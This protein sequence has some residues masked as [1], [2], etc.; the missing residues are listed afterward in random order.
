MMARAIDDNLAV[1][2]GA[3]DEWTDEAATFGD[4]LAHARDSVGMSQAQ[5]AQRM[6][7]RLQTVRNWEEN[8]SEPRSNRL[9]TLA[10]MLNVSMVWLMCGQGAAPRAQ[11]GGAADLVSELRAVRLDHSRLADRLARLESRLRQGLR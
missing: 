9:Q 2:E 11:P 7:I 6:G 4:R 8:R 3:P 10:G 5:L 1:P